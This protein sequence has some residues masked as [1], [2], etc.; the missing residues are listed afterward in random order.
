M[1]FGRFPFNQNLRN[2]ENNGNWYSIFP[3][4]FPD[5][6]KPFPNANHSTR[7]FRHSGAKLNAE[8]NFPKIIFENFGIYRENAIPFGT[9]WKL[10]QI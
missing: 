5:F 7:N 9:A 10:P 6:R 2:F 3:E 8:E 4:K 1:H